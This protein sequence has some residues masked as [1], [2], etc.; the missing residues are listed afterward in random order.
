[1]NGNTITLDFWNKA[2]RRHERSPKVEGFLAYSTIHFIVGSG[3]IS[4]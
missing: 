1:V 4:T 3:E 2:R